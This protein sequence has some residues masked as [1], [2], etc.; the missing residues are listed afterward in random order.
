ML[1][2]G[3]SQRN[4]VKLRQMFYQKNQLNGEPNVKPSKELRK[5][6]QEK[7]CAEPNNYPAEEIDK[8]STNI[9]RAK[10]LIF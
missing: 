5:K 8:E 1:E 9:P 7:T 2:K 6:P 10:K 3:A 4:P